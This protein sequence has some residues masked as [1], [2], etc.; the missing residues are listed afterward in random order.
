[1]RRLVF[2]APLALVA[3]AVFAGP[4]LA[5]PPPF[6]ATPVPL[7]NVAAALGGDH[8]A[9]LGAATKVATG[10]LGP[11]EIVVGVVVA[12]L[13]QLLKRWEGFALVPAEAAGAVRA[14]LVILTVIGTL[15]AG[16]ADGSVATLDLNAISAQLVDAAQILIVATVAWL[17]A[18]KGKGQSAPP[19]PKG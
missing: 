11:K 15:V 4:A 7:P 6:G 17:A 2:L 18:F 19:T 13:V 3:A 16:V 5:I 12:V 14:L 1:M 10:Q 9:L 8:G